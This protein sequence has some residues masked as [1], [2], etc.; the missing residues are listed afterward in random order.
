M[1]LTCPYRQSPTITLW[2]CSRA[3]YKTPDA[4]RYF[5][6]CFP[7]LIWKVFINFSTQQW[8]LISW[9]T[10]TLCPCTTWHGRNTS[11]YNRLYRYHRF[12]VIRLIC[13]FK[14][15]PHCRWGIQKT[16]ILLVNQHLNTYYSKWLWQRG[17]IPCP[18]IKRGESILAG[19]VIYLLK[20]YTSA[21]QRSHT[22][23]WF[24]SFHLPFSNQWK[25]SLQGKAWWGGAL[26][27]LFCLGCQKEIHH[28][29]YV[30]EEFSL[31]NAFCKVLQWGT[32]RLIHQRKLIHHQS[33]SGSS[34]VRAVNRALGEWQIAGWH[35]SPPLAL[36]LT[37]LPLPTPRLQLMHIIYR[38]FHIPGWYPVDVGFN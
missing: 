3:R 29:L 13:E 26:G 2:V 34:L 21:H 12:L 8:L 22:I 18:A 38:A 30:N 5:C 4:T 33:E 15:Y 14:F 1:I 17:I 6:W 28:D 31:G 16:L 37:T 35:V 23:K 7:D 9:L 25:F 27:P 10:D 20:A 11:V 32:G 36:P 24:H 19:E